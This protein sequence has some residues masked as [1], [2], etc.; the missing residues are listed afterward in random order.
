[1]VYINDFN[2]CIMFRFNLCFIF[3]SKSKKLDVF[4]LIGL[5]IIETIPITKITTPIKAKPI[6][7]TNKHEKMMKFR[8]PNSNTHP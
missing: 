5:I 6:K 3:L 1:M 8:V 2:Y 7:R 4:L